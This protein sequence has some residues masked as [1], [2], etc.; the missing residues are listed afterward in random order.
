M[1]N[2]AAALREVLARHGD[3]TFAVSG[4]VDSLTLA[5]FAGRLGP[6]TVAHA[7]SPAVPKEATTRV[8]ELARVENWTL[9]VIEAG[10]FADPDYLRNPLNRCYFCKSNLYARIQQVVPGLIA[11]GTN[12]DDLSE[13]RPGLLAARENRVVHPY[14]EAGLSKADLRRLSAE[15]GLGEIAELPAQPCLASRVETGIPIRADDLAFIHRVESTLREFTDIPDLRCRVTR[16][17][18][19]L[20][21]GGA[22]PAAATARIAAMCRESGRIFA[23]VAAHRR[24]SAFVAPEP[25]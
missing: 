18:I 7:V 3:L 15:I 16:S 24:G 23:G 14:V 13:F 21:A 11:A 19:R 9:H 12:T 20:E 22:L 25:S 8:R 5:A 1:N 6:I 10:E 2:P 17:G 4:G